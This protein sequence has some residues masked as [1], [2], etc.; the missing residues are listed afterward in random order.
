MVTGTEANEPGREAAAWATEGAAGKAAAKT[1]EGG[2]GT[3]AGAC[4]T[5]CRAGT[6]A[7]RVTDSSGGA[8]RSGVGLGAGNFAD[9]AAGC[10]AIR[11][12]A[13]VFFTRTAA[14]GTETAAG[15][16]NCVAVYR[17]VGD[18]NGERT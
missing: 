7:V 9:S 8:G 16:Y 15:T 18:S 13:G 6:G 14:A 12:N 5:G 3:V 17:V 4:S 2:A 1:A 11:G 10:G